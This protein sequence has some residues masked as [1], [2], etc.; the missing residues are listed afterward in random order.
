MLPDIAIP[1][2]RGNWVRVSPDLSEG[3]LLGYGRHDVANAVADVIA[4]FGGAA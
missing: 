3:T 2:G 4:Q 1:Q